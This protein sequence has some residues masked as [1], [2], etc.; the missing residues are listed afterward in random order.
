MRGSEFFVTVSV[1]CAAVC[2]G[3]TGSNERYPVSGKVLCNGAPAVGATVTFVRKGG[4]DQFADPTPQGVV[5]D[6]GTFT[7]AGPAGPGASPGEYA[8]LVEW[9]EGAG[10]EKGRGPALNSPDRLQKRYLDPNEPLLT[11]TVEA[12]VNHLPPFDLK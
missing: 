8:V 3:C 7:L 6:D 1:A 12:K 9:K 10:K 2:A 5:E 4:T 11:A